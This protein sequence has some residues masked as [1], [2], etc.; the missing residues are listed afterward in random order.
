MRAT[1]KAD[2]ALSMLLRLEM[3]AAVARAYW[4]ALREPESFRQ[5]QAAACVQE[6]VGFCDEED[7][8]DHV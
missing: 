6:G 7:C 4:P 1:A 5:L 3:A 8:I 2:T